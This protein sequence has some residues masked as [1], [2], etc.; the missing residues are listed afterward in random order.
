LKP[1][2]LKKRTTILS[3]S[4]HQCHEYTSIHT[5]LS[6]FALSKQLLRLTSL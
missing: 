4:S 3:R 2:V 6:S 1:I 5:T